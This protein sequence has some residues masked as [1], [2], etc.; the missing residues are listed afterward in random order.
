MTKAVF[1]K[2]TI[3]GGLVVRLAA[4]CGYAAEVPSVAA[5]GAGGGYLFTHMRTGR[6]YGHLYFDVSRD[7]VT[8][9]H[10]NWGEGVIY[11]VIDRK[12]FN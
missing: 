10:A 4:V 2:I 6:E 3:I 5:D 9:T 12:M 7:G 11:A 1:I 8:W